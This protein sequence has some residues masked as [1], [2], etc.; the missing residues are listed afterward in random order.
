VVVAV[1]YL[2]RE[3]RN[4]FLARFAADS[5]VL[6]VAFSD[7]GGSIS[8]VTET[9]ERHGVEIR[10]LSGEIEEGQARYTIQL[11][12]PSRLGVQEVLE[13]ISTLPGVERLSVTG[14]RE[15]E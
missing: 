8:E 3:V 5:G 14:L 7:L 10:S 6:Q 4:R 1:L 15:V 13:G 11:R 9:L 12:I 2:L